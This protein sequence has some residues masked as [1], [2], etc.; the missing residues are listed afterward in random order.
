MHIHYFTE[1]VHKMLLQN[2]VISPL[3]QKFWHV[4]KCRVKLKLLAN[5]RKKICATLSSILMVLVPLVHIKIARV[6][7]I[8]M[9][10]VIFRVG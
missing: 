7:M 10:T 2:Q 1:N 4:K 8:I 9:I 5:C 6:I 3:S